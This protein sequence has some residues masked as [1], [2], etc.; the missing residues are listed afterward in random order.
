MKR[1]ER[2]PVTVSFRIVPLLKSS[3]VSSSSPLD[4][5][6][7]QQSLDAQAQTVPRR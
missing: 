4:D 3:Q 1:E 2:A 5:S 7:G 6:T